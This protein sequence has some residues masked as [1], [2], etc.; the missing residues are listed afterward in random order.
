MRIPLVFEGEQAN[1]AYLV[2]VGLAAP[3][4]AHA[5]SF[6]LPVTTHFAGCGCCRPRGPVVEALTAMFRA[7]ATGAAPYF[8]QVV[9]RASPRGEAAVRDAIARDTVVRARYRL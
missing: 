8:Q 3:A 5:A 9:V 2:E 1:A 7:R 4:A 6:T